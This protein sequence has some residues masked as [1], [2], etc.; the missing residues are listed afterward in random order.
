ML[1]S[2]VAIEH[3]YLSVTII[4]DWFILLKL[5]DHYHRWFPP[6]HSPRLLREKTKGGFGTRQKVQFFFYFSYV[7][8]CKRKLCSVFLTR[9][10]WN[11]TVFYKIFIFLMRYAPFSP[12]T[13][14]LFFNHQTL[15]STSCHNSWKH[16]SGGGSTA[17]AHNVCPRF[18][19][20]IW[21]AKS[22]HI[23]TQ[24]KYKSV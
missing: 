19:H 7:I 5:E 2:E 12:N 23:F 21:Q 18:P 24:R 22:N 3:L 14:F 20:S 4:V 13:L 8:Y 6:F 1:C 16:N 17:C 11:K 10:W 15:G 9:K